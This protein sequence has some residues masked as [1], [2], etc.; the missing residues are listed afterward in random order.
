MSQHNENE[1]LEYQNIKR[2]LQKTMFQIGLKKKI[3]LIKK[4]KNT[5]LYGMS[6]ISDFTDEQVVGML[7]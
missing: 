4:V 6:I 7:Y 3:G 2:F 5:V 1:A